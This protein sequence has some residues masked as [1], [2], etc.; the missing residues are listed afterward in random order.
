VLGVPADDERIA[1][2]VAFARS[3]NVVTDQGLFVGAFH[4]T[5]WDTAH[6]LRVL[7]RLPAGRP[8]PRRAV[9][10]LLAEQ[11]HVPAPIDWQTPPPGAPQFGGWAW[12]SGNVRNPDIDSTAEIL[13]ALASFRD[14]TGAS[15]DVDAAIALGADWLV[16]FQN[17]DGGWAAFSHG[18]R[19]APP[20]P[21]YVKTSEDVRLRDI[22]LRLDRW[23]AENG[24]PS[25]A[26]VTGRVLHALGLLGWRR[27]DPRIC[28]A[29]A[30]LARH[31]LASGAWWSRWSVC[32]LPA[33]SY[34]V[35]GLLA[36]G[37]PVN[38]PLVRRAVDWMLARQNSD[39]GWGESPA[40]F[41][42]PGLAGTG[43]SSVQITGI[44][45]W[46]L[47]RAGL[48]TDPRLSAAVQYL[49]ERQ[50]PDGSWDDRT[51]YGT[52]FPLIHHYY[53]DTFPTYFAMEALLEHER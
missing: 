3:V 38:S 11:S 45:T 22:R 1:R 19:S 4:C 6:M 12:Q 28:A 41:E 47:L 36:V 37:E 27:D 30:F 49:L 43:P 29:V 2:A 46:A 13:S 35:A 33:T 26:D 25:T 5:N 34:I 53:T 21:L 50:Q 23:L 18:K 39:G 17:P 24:D 52:I 32:Y 7:A 14:A 15:G 16:P 9:E 42:D 44:V 48:R 51:C 10:Y 31:Q 8:E 20:G 40:A